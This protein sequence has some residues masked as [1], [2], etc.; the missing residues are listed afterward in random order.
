MPMARGR[1]EAD[2]AI[3]AIFGSIAPVRF[4]VHTNDVTGPTFLGLA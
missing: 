4:K 2:E 1:D 3:I